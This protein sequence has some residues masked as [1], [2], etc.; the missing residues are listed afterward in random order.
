[1]VS[2]LQVAIKALCEVLF[3]TFFLFSFSTPLAHPIL[4]G[5]ITLNLRNTNQETPRG[6]TFSPSSLYFHILFHGATDP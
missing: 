1:M 3:P 2:F 4:L 6:I 5:V